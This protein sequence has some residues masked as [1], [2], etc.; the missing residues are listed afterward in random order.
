MRTHSNRTSSGL[1]VLVAAA[2]VVPSPGCGRS[3][4]TRVSDDVY[5]AESVPGLRGAGEKI[6]SAQEQIRSAA[7]REGVRREL[8]VSVAPKNVL[9]T[10]SFRVLVDRDSIRVEGSDAG[11]ALYGALTMA[12]MIREGAEITSV[13]HVRPLIPLRIVRTDLRIPGLSE[14]PSRLDWDIFLDRLAAAR[15]NILLIGCD[16]VFPSLVNLPRYPKAFAGGGSGKAS[17]TQGP[18]RA[19]REFLTKA[20][21]RNVRVVI[22][23]RVLSAPPSFLRNYS[24]AAADASPNSL[25]ERSYSLECLTQ[26]LQAYPEIAG[27]ALRAEALRGVPAGDAGDFVERVFVEA[28]RGSRGRALLIVEEGASSGIGGLEVSP[29]VDVLREESWVPGRR[30]SGRPAATCYRIPS[31]AIAPSLPRPETIRSVIEELAALKPGGFILEAFEASPQPGH[32]LEADAL[33]AASFGLASFDPPIDLE[34]VGLL[35][36]E[37]L[38]GDAEDFRTAAGRLGDVWLELAALHPPERGWSP[39]TSTELPAGAP[40]ESGI[41]DGSPFVSILEFAFSPSVRSRCLT[42][43]EQVASE[44]RGIPPGPGKRTPEGVG[45]MLLERSGEALGIL[46][47][48]GAAGNGGGRGEGGPG[49]VAARDELTFMSH[50]GA[51]H[52]HRILAALSLMR[53]VAGADATMREAAG[54]SIQRALESWTRAERQLGARGSASAR[55]AD[56]ARWRD[57]VMNDHRIVEETQPDPTG[58]RQSPVVALWPFTEDL[59]LRSVRGFLNLGVGAF[60]NPPVVCLGSGQCIEAEDHAG[61]WHAAADLPGYSGEGYVSSGCVG[62]PS[63]LPV[64]FRILQER[65]GTYHIWVRALVGGGDGSPAI[66]LRVG[67]LDLEPTHS[68]SDGPR[69]FGWERAGQVAFTTGEIFL[70]IIDAGPG[71]EGVDALVITPDADWRPPVF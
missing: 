66:R 61:S 9:G 71:R 10:E 65:S 32:A 1:A 35:W 62:A 67:S 4:F 41:R 23:P 12:R 45:I 18:R 54:A 36:R 69:T 55:F 29:P 52:G 21:E 19:L 25:L 24:S 60:A 28:L 2:M 39:I 53:Y 26:L 6:S 47:A 49:A 13:Q 40:A 64:A 38:G 50:L 33:V 70:Q 46:D 63:S 31:R 48:L 20:L 7:P 8:S 3:G 27:F 57:A 56:F 30:V 51:Y 42:I 15:I 11:G 37:L 68:S 14:E 17:T 58:F 43:P 5:V 16:D 44:I 22:A 34:S 59:D